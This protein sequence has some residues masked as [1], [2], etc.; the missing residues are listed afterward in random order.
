VFIG[1]GDR[2]AHIPLLRVQH[3]ADV[4]AR[5][6]GAVTQRIYPGMGHTVNEDE[7]SFARALL[8]EIAS[9]ND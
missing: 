2:D 4:L 8:D 3:S 1:C 6:G 9:Q 5:L 7:L